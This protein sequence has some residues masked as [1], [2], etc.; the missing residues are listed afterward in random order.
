[1]ARI[2]KLSFL[3]ALA[4]VS[5][6][7]SVTAQ[8]EDAAMLDDLVV[9]GTRSASPLLEQAGNTAKVSERD[10]DLVR[11]EHVTE[12]VNRV[13]GVMVQRGNGQEHL[14]SLR[15]PVLTGGAGA[16][17]F[18]YLEDGIPLRAAGFANVNGLFE[19]NH[20]QAGGIEVVRGPGSAFY[21]SNAVHGLMNFL[22]RAPSLDLEREIDL[23]A[24]SNDT[25][26]GKFTISDTEGR[27]GYR[28]SFNGITD[29]GFT[30]RE[31]PERPG[32]GRKSGYDQQKL[33]FRHDYYGDID[34]FT[35]VFSATN[36]NQETQGYVP[37]ERAY[38]SKRASETR[39]SDSYRDAKATRLS[40]RWDRELSD[41]TTLSLTPY[42]RYTEMEFL[43]DFLPGAP[44]EKNKHTS[45]GL[46]AAYAMDLDGGHRVIFGTDFEYTE[47]SLSEVQ[48]NPAPSAFSPFIPG[49][50]Y[51]YDVDAT[52]VA[53]YVHSEWQVAE[54]TRITAGLRYEHTRYEY[55]DNTGSVTLEGSSRYIRPEDQNDTF[56]NVSPKLG[57]V[58]ALSDDTSAFINLARGNRAPQTTDLYRLVQGANPEIG[59]AKSEDMDSAEIGI[60]RV[61]EGL[62]Y[63]IATY[64]MR[65]KNYFFRDSANDNIANGKTEHYGLE[66]GAFYPFS[67]QW[68]IAA[69][70]TFA[71]HLFDFD[72]EGNV[73]F[74]GAQTIIR[75]GN[76]M[77]YAPRR[78]A[79]VRLGWNFVKDSRAELEWIHVDD[80][81]VTESNNENYSGHDIFNLRAYHAINSKL[82][83]HG[84]INNLFDTRYAERADFNN[85]EYRYFVGQ[86][87]GLHAGFTYSF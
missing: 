33:T 53:P 12:I 74:S 32:I 73:A 71:R 79:N 77:P 24:G 51:D 83:I 41:S 8:E 35:T 56:N 64:Y 36:L 85:G 22:T 48:F 29:G 44:V 34:T 16:G 72:N 78:M 40:T 17:S 5:L 30:D 86:S 54:N 82:T 15:S 81:F 57:L 67:E 68:D 45:A 21:G 80:Y 23:S 65:K 47:G 52:V 46:L 75:D 6:P 76:Y 50:H 4:A 43:M 28:L 61:G 25:Y 13:P 84:R 26:R 87:R 18:L 20:E 60:R 42:F 59:R 63:E 3:M 69:N 66:I 1:M 19:V 62:Q 10:I 38:R 58:Q 31:D 39:Y 27:H 37:G 7:Y 14:T 49:V 55:S 11:A 9:T 2:R 70:V